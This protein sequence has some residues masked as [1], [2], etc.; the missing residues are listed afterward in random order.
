MFVSEVFISFETAK[1]LKEKNFEGVVRA[2]YDSKGEG[3]NHMPEGTSYEEPTQAL[4]MRWLRETHKLD[5][6]PFHE[7]LD[8]EF[9]WCRIERLPFTMHQQ[10]EEYSTY[11]EA[12]E[13]AI[14]YC[15]KNLL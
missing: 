3:W 13:N 12:V 6:I 2:Y 9:W 7:R 14:Q 15:L 10:Q 8:K 4:V 1:L 5:I 11:E